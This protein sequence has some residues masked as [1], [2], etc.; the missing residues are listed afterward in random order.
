MP[1]LRTYDYMLNDD[2]FRS[3]SQ[4]LRGSH[5]I[6]PGEPVEVGHRRQLLMDWH[7]VDDLN[8]C[9][10]TV[11]QPVKHPDN[12]LVGG[13]PGQ[14][15]GPTSWGSV[16]RDP[17]TGLFRIWTNATDPQL[18]AKLGGKGPIGVLNGVY[19]ESDDGLEWRRPSL[20]MFEHYGSKDNNVFLHAGLDNLYVLPL[21]ERMRERG[22]YGM[23]YC[24]NLP[25]DTV[26][27]KDTHTMRNFIS[28]SDDGISWTDAPENPVWYGRTDTNNCIIY[29]PDRDVFMMYRRATINAGEIRRIAYSESDDLISWT[30]PVTIVTQDELDPIY[31]YGMPVSLY[32]GV[33]FGYLQCLHS[34]P[35]YQNHSLGDGKDFKMDTQ[36]AWSR[37]GVSWDRHPERPTFIPNSAPYKGSYDWGMARG[38]ANMIEVGD[39]VYIYYGGYPRLHPP[40]AAQSQL[41]QGICLAT[42]KRDR[43]V[44]LD[45]GDY[46]GYMLTK[47]M[48]YHG[49]DLHINARAKG[50]G[51]IRVAV[52]EGEGIR[53][54]EWPQGW[55]FDRS[56]TFSGDSLDHVMAWE[57]ADSLGSFPSTTM[58]LHF[59]MESAELY[60]FWFE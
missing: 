22:R 28:F 30:Q 44:S 36:L 32:N 50:D 34:H 1:T 38:M 33:Y 46:G 13:A 48:A 16:M 21:P 53:D 23:V 56:A 4:T 8:G 51:F 6:I 54:G 39:E 9:R 17:N 37:D 2:V 15:H 24:N 11:H 41:E 19:F 58:R 10:R 60:S 12:P 14:D 49:G 5:S 59:W 26:L 31:L 35:D 29:N 27:P 43:L 25:P 7:V 40:S 18:S 47:P 55:R 3:G 20:G 52:R 42:V 45:A 57:G